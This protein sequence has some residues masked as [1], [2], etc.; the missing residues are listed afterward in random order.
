MIIDKINKKL[1][2][3]MKASQK[4]EVLAVRNILEKI[5][6]R[7]LDSQ[8]QLNEN[9]IIQVI[10]KYAKQLRDSIEQF[11]SGNRIDLAEKEKNELKIVKQFLPQQLTR[12]EINTI[13]TN[14]IAKTDAQNMSDMGRVMKEVINTTQGSADGKIISELVREHLK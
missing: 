8:K 6:K 4:D 2:T 7:Q 3:A 12:E 11:E 13:V 1:K 14:V 10:N 5:K 9:E